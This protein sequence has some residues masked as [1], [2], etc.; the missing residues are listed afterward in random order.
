MQ[1]LFRKKLLSAVALA[2]LAGSGALA[3]TAAPSNRIALVLGNSKYQAGPLATAAND[4]GLVASTLRAEGFD[5]A[6]AADVTNAQLVSAINDFL[7]KASALGPDGVAFVYLG[8]YGLQYNGDDYFPGVD[9]KVSAAA[10]IPNNGIPLGALE[11]ALAGMNIAG[12]IF[13]LDGARA[14]PFAPGDKSIAG[15]LAMVDPPNGALV[16]F[17]AAPGTIGPSESGT[18]GAYAQA[19]AGAL[20]TGGLTASQVFDETRLRVSDTTKGA[21]IP[22]DASKIGAGFVFGTAP[23]GVRPA[24]QLAALQDTPIPTAGAQSAFA[25]ALAQDTIAAYEA[26]LNAYPNDPLAKRVRALLAARREARTW[27]DASSMNTPGAYWSYLRRYPHG[28]HVGD[29]EAAL[30]LLRAEMAPPPN[31]VP[32]VFDVPPP[33]PVEIEYVGAPYVSFYNPAWALPP[34]PPAYYLPPMP[35][36]YPSTPPL[37]PQFQYGLPIVQLAIGA[38]IGGIVADALGAGQ[39][40]PAGPGKIIPMPYA[41]QQIPAP[42]L[43]LTPQQQI[44][45]AQAAAK[46]GGLNKPAPLLSP[47]GQ[48]LA[49]LPPDVKNQLIQNAMANGVNKQRIIQLAPKPEGQL[50]NA[51][52]GQGQ[53]GAGGLVGGLRLPSQTPAN[54]QAMPAPA[55]AEGSAGRPAT[56]ATQPLPLPLPQPSPQPSSAGQQAARPNPTAPPGPAANEGKP[57]PGNLGELQQQHAQQ[58]QQQQ[59][60]VNAAAQ[61]AAQQAAQ[62][63][64]QQ[65]QQ[66]LQ[67]QQ[68][69]AQQALAARQAQQ[70]QAA[71]AADQAKLA[72]QHAQEQQALQ[73]QHEQQQQQML[74]EQ[75]QQ[76]AAMAAQ[77]AQQAQ[78]LTQQRQQMMQQHQQ[79]AAPAPQR[80]APGPEP[81]RR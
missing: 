63:Q 78:Q 17:N 65:Q 20:A 69:Q 24:A 42:K 35:V 64:Q 74:R 45:F 53:Q 73:Q 80:P 66:L 10:D 28:P 15:G 29:A 1:T 4:A 71:A 44:D 19:L 39:G 11:Q 6:G 9:A 68:Q 22:W 46:N 16:A 41:P 49:N 60:Q 36:F 33:P 27:L 67:Q 31:F 77:H 34:P 3:Q 75:Q 50:A 38:A 54:G 56:G 7:A 8:G 37:A 47:T 52:A 30:A 23:Q 5:V 18:Y 61:Q 13:V 62:H 51:P 76:Q 72:A 21:E 25:S 79:M 26:F 59:Q 2:T 14:N 55:Q 12:R 40:G 81:I 48:Q 58:L 70:A 57:L 32:V 43:N